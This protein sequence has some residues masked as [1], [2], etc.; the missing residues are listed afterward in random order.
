MPRPRLHDDALGAR[1]LEIASQVIS[2]SGAAGLTVRDVAHRAGTSTSAVY[3]LFGSRDALVA[4]V[5]DEAFRRFAAHLGAVPRTGDPRADLLALGAAYRASAV[6]DPHLYRVMFEV[7]GTDARG[8]DDTPAIARPTFTV[9]R[10]AVL[11]VLVDAG[12]DRSEAD[13]DALEQALVLWALVH[14]LVGL[15]LG[16]LVPGDDAD[17]AERYARALGT[18][19]TA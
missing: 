5:G 13:A 3:A 10:D 11:R 6:G 15:E 18:A 14:G 8:D 1:L 12:L 19:G 4:A 17:R 9:L 7:S 16:G 2:V